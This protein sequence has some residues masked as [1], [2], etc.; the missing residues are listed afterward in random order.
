MTLTPELEAEGWAADRIRGIQDARRTEDFDVSDRISLV[1]S[2]PEERRG[3]A[4][5]H[6]GTIAAETLATS[7]KVITGEVLAHD[8]GDG[9]TVSVERVVES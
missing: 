9:C 3:W 2:V 5:T 1:L 4:D 6:I 8:T 7:T